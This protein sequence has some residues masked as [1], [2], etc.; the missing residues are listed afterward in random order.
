MYFSA[1]ITYLS[2]VPIP[3]HILYAC[4]TIIVIENATARPDKIVLVDTIIT[5]SI[6]S[7]N[8]F[9]SRIIYTITYRN[10]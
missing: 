2:T 3:V 8:N 1:H 7:K 6:G 5:H 4:V 9:P 10:I